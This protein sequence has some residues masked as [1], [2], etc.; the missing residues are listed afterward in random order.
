MKIAAQ[1]YTYISVCF[2]V[3]LVLVLF[4]PT[5]AWSI[6]PFVLGTFVA[7][8]FRDPK[9]TPP[10]DSKL[11]VSPADG[12]VVYVGPVKEAKDGEDR[13]Q[14]SIF[15]SIFNVHINRSP[16]AAVV[17]RVQYTPGRFLA[18]YRPEASQQNEQ[19]EVELADGE[20]K[21]TVRQIAGVVARRIVFTKK[22]GDQ[23]GRGERFGL[24]QFGSRVDVL[25]PS[26]VGV[27]V[28]VGDRVK[29]GESV[30]VE[31]S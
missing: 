3:G 22:E 18:A 4:P 20:W 31:R 28:A 5:R 12:K 14:I 26:E 13:I 2:M 27:R 10:D 9:R 21:C 25:L 23:L 6:L 24:I 1:G 15:L 17:R 30:L 19:N 29:G 8:F 11:L 7:F 16:L